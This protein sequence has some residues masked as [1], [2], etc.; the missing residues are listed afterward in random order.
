MSLFNLCLT[1]TFNPCSLKAV[2][3]DER[4]HIKFI[5]AIENRLERAT[6]WERCFPL[7]RTITTETSA[8]A[9]LELY[10]RN[11]CLPD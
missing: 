6:E 2:F 7:L 4:V 1:M 5:H 10:I 9:V 8:L 3:I 11:N